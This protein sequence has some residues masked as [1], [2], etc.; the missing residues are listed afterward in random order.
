MQVYKSYK[1]R[2]YPTLEQIQYLSMCFGHVRL[3]WN[4]LVKNFNSW[5]ATGPNRPMSEKTLKDDPQYSFLKDVPA[6]ILQQK[7]NDFDE[8]K[9]Q[10]FSKTRKKKLGRPKFKK[11]GSHES[12]RFPAST[13]AIK[14]FGA[15]KDG[16]I[17]LPKLERPIKIVVHREFSGRPVS[18]TISKTPSNEYY[19]S[20]LVEEDVET[21]PV[22]HREVGIDLGLTDLIITSSGIK[23][24]R[25]K[26]QL[27]KANRLLKKTQKKLA[28]KQNGSKSR[29][30]ARIGVAKLYARITRIRNDYYHNISKWLIENHDAIY[31]ED[32]NV[33]GML[34]NRRMARAIQ[35]AAWSTLVAMIIYKANWAGRTVHKIDRWYPSS[36]TCNCCG[37]KV[38]KLPLDIREWT[39]PNCGT[40]HDRDIN[41]AINIRK[42]GQLD[43]YDQ[44]LSDGTADM[45][46]NIPMRLEKYTVKT[47]R[48]GAKALV[49]VGTDEDTR[50]LVEY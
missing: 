18:F 37:H 4:K 15:I 33:N 31:L 30:K 26:K 2:L 9:R 36:K 45:G 27:E 32:L 24:N 6:V 49:G 41:A 48:P 17:K 42:H 12:I 1:Y 40:H 38:D 43:C 10:H 22:V 8:A 35:E 5:S 21:Q 3:V 20:I 47:E 23:F 28:K 19:V 11:R 25:V 39:C 13:T 44:L 29:E 14:S 16:F 50:S 34:K 46:Y 7:A